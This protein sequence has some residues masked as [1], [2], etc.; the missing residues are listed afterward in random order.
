[1]N[2]SL[3]PTTMNH[4]IVRI[5]TLLAFVFAGSGIAFAAEARNTGPWKMD[6]LKLP[7]GGEFTAGPSLVQEV[8]YDNVPYK[9]KP[10][11]VFAYYGVPTGDGPFPA[12]LCVH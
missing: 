9:G 5:V 4:S 10:T 11:K 2:H 8:W 1:M 12:M 6:E 7:I 3:H